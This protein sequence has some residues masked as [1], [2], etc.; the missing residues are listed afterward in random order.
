MTRV[1]ISIPDDLLR[2][3]KESG[4]N[5]SKLTREAIMRELRATKIAAFDEYVAELEAEFGP[6]TAEQV[7]EAKAWADEI[8]GPVTESRKTA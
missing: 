5:I 1:N 3:A 2:Q 8:F 4:L 6:P 7:A